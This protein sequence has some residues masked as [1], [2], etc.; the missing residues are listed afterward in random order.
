MAQSRGLENWQANFKIT[1]KSV[2]L[3]DYFDL[4]LF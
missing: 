1:P 2:E 4:D 3:K